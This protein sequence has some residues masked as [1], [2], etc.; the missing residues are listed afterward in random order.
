MGPNENSG[1]RVRET[2][3]AVEIGQ[4]VSRCVVRPAGPNDEG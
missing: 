1:I 2:L 4:T 3:P